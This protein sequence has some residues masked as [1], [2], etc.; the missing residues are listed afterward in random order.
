MNRK[1]LVMLIV[2]AFVA[3]LY[4][5]ITTF[6]AFISFGNLQFR[7]AEMLNHLFAFDQRYGYGIIGGVVLANT[8]FMSSSG[9]GFY[10]LIFGVAHS[11]ISFVISAFLFRFTEKVTYKLLIVSV[12]FSVMIFL[13]A[14]ELVLVFELP[15]WLSYL[16]TFLGEFVVLLLGIPI[17]RSI[18]KLVAFE[19]LFDRF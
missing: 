4:V 12:I 2:N 16:E 8:V 7:I 19:K 6:F 10:D 11:V 5:V 17:M 14:L 15:F 9:L 1:K 3:A 18:D 13:V